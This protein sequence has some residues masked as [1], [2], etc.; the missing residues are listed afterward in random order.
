MRE[1]A[2]RIGRSKD[3]KELVRRC[4]QSS[5]VAANMRG[6]DL[7]MRLHGLRE[8]DQLRSVGIGAR[9]VH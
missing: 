3:V 5:L 1:Q 7:A 4:D 6:Q 8:R 9:R 2:G